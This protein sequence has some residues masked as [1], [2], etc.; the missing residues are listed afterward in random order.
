MRNGVHMKM[1]FWEYK[2]TSNNEHPTLNIECASLAIWEYSMFDVQCSVFD[3]LACDY[4]SGLDL[5]RHTQHVF[6]HV[7]RTSNEG[8]AA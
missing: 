6:A 2:K 4:D 8:P 5:A 3:V 1:E 7:R